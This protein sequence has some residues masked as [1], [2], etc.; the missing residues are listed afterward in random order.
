MTGPEYVNDLA[1]SYDALPYEGKPQPPTHPDNLATVATLYGLT[2]PPVERCRVLEIGCADGANLVPM[3]ATMP[4]AE[5]V[6]IDLSPRQIA[7]AR[8][9]ADALGLRNIRLETRSVTDVDDS[10]GG[11]D[12]VICH[13]V[14]SWVPPDVQHKIL[15]VCR[16]NLTP[17]GVAY[18]SYNTLPGWYVRA[19]ARDLMVFHTRRLDAPAEKVRQARTILDYVVQSLPH[20]DNLYSRLLHEEADLLRDQRDSYVY[21]EHL[22]GTNSAVYFHE[23]VARAAAKGLQYLSEAAYPTN[24]HEHSADLRDTMAKLSPDRIHLEQYLDFVSNRMFRRTLLCHS[25]PPVA[26]APS[27]D[28]LMRCG[29]TALAR[30]VG[31]NLDV[32]S[33]EMT[34]E[35]RTDEGFSATTYAPPIKAALLAAFEAWPRCVP[36]D[37]LWQLTCAKL[38]APLE[39]EVRPALANAL[40][41]CWLTNVIEIHLTQAPLCLT[42]GERPVAFA[43]ARFQAKAGASRVCNLRHRSLPMDD[44]YR[45]LLPLMDGTRDLATLRREAGD[46]PDFDARLHNLARNSLVSA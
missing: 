10:F 40:L 18:V 42:V 24:P 22:E 6:G 26:A 21:H 1:A 13:G 2:P 44:V 20:Q 29:L 30:P 32:V 34:I 45:R 3:A 27:A 37:E 15:D 7:D 35:F 28:A 19:A 31:D 33:P 39:D 17:G 46:P 38:P 36:F 14:Y 43:V 23:F 16:R 5:F 25:G 4:Q 41:Q 9:M 12:Y 8:T 11:F